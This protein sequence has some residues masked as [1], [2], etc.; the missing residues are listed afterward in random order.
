MG[1]LLIHVPLAL[2][3]VLSSSKRLDSSLPTVLSLLNVSIETEILLSF[4][5]PVRK[6]KMR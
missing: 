4:K 3:L 6:Q 2:K 1:F 5:L